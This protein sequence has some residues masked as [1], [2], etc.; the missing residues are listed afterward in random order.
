MADSPH[1]VLFI[2]RNSGG[3]IF[4]DLITAE[5]IE[6]VLHD[7]RFPDPRTP[8]REW[9]AAVGREGWTMITGDINVRRSPLFLADLE[10]SAARVFILCGL[11]GKSREEKA[12]CIISEYPKIM[13]IV[14]D[15]NGPLLWKINSDGSSRQVDFRAHLQKMRKRKKA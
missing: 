1:E 8:D 12:A 7:E 5:G 6:V 2:D 15:N 9:L 14:E 3:R 13:R 10:R 11:N 4:R